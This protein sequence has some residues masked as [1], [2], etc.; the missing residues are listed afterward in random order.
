MTA[1]PTEYKLLEDESYEY[2]GP[3]A[4]C[5]GGGGSSP[6]SSTTQQAVPWSGVQ[7]N[8]ANLYATASGQRKDMMSKYRDIA[9]PDY[10]EQ[11]GQ[12]RLASQ[13]QMGGLQPYAQ[14]GMA[15]TL[16]G[17]YFDQAQPQQTAAQLQNTL[18]GK[19]ADP[20]LDWQTSRG[21]SGTITGQGF[22]PAL[23]SQARGQLGFTMG[24]G[25]VD[26]S[27]QRPTIQ[28]LQGAVRGADFNP[29]MDASMQNEMMRT[30]GGSYL[31][32][33]EGFKQAFDAAASEIMPRVG[34]QFAGSGTYTGDLRKAA[35]SKELSREFAKMY[36][37]ERDRQ[38]QATGLAADVGEASRQRQMQAMQ[39]TT[40][41]T[42]A[43]RAR[44]MEAL[45]LTTGMSEAERDRQMQAM[46]ISTGMSQAE[47]QRQMEA[48]GMTTGMLGDERQR[49]MQAL[50]LTPSIDAMRYV[51][52]QLLQDVGAQRRADRE[53]YHDVPWE[54]LARESAILHG[55][56]SP[57]TV[58][59]ASGGGMS[60]MGGAIGGGMLGSSFGPWGALG[61]AVLGGL[62]A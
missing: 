14:Q 30:M 60:P 4:E 3:V 31:T 35:Q 45:G 38:L 52:G 47:R 22:D 36:G 11:L 55:F 49:Q 18:S 61:G 5:I 8:L 62:L 48:L 32:G 23:R 59:E 25:Y 17:R 39:L 27:I 56:M 16:Q 57:T 19:F 12:Q 53:R 54:A 15:H 41:M 26:P 44:Q 28:A 46:G 50:G 37:Q 9:K 6:P 42:E 10:Y 13:A 43:E 33:G 58:T 40:G 21:L 20:G 34:A 1:D 2:D 29:W 51:P 7:Q 24:G